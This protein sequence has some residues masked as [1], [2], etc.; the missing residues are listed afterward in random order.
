MPVGLHMHGIIKSSLHQHLHWNIGCTKLHIKVNIRMDPPGFEPGASALQGRRSPRLSYGPIL[1][2]FDRFDLVSDCHKKMTNRSK[3]IRFS[4]HQTQKVFDCFFFVRRW[5]S[6][7][8]PYGYLV[9]TSPSS[10]NPDSTPTIRLRPHPN[11]FWVAWRA[12]CARS[13]D[14][15]TARLWHAITTHSSF[16]RASY[17]PRSELR[18]CLRD[19]LHLSVSEPIVTAIVARV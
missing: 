12:V 3:I 2:W 10:K 16:T 7:R 6:R 17:S 8:F 15:F 13:R 9:T 14:V 19:Y 4:A 1:S 18:L 11:P 5:S